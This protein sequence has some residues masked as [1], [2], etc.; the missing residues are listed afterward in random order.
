MAT[1]ARRIIAKDAAEIS[2]TLVPREITDEILSYFVKIPVDEVKE[3]K[4]EYEAN[5]KM[6]NTFKTVEFGNSILHETYCET[7]GKKKWAEIAVHSRWETACYA[8][9]FHHQYCED[10]GCVGDVLPPYENHNVD[11]SKVFLYPEGLVHYERQEDK[12]CGT[13]WHV[14]N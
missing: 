6:Y 1:K 2:D 8:N 14:I 13:A 10:N 3:M 4:V 5:E 12:W 7:C 11:R 9:H